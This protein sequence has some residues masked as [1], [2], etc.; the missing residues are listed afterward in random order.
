MLR[1]TDD[2]L[3]QWTCLMHPLMVSRSLRYIF[4]LFQVR[5]FDGAKDISTNSLTRTWKSDWNK[6][7]QLRS[8][9]H[10]TIGCQQI[11]GS[12]L[13]NPDFESDRQNVS[14]I[15]FANTAYVDLSKSRGRPATVIQHMQSFWFYYR[16][17]LVWYNFVHVHRL[18][19][20]LWRL[21]TDR[22]IAR[23][24]NEKRL[25]TL[26]LAILKTVNCLCVLS[27]RT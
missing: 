1:T 17:F 13:Q 19:S 14:T 11:L 10:R 6:T 16:T 22:T 20:S 9:Q 24:K 5:D 2:A 26:Q 21:C 27:S 4:L 15:R 8:S 7:R 23:L 18:Y 3:V 25:L 12:W